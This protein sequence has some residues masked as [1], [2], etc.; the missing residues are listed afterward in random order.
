MLPHARSP[1]AAASPHMLANARR[2]RVSRWANDV[3]VAGA[4]DRSAKAAPKGRGN[5]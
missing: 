3:E 1:H 4:E 5:A 2:R